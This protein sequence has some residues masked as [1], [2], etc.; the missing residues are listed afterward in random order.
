MGRNKYGYP[1]PDQTKFARSKKHKQEF[2]EGGK[3]AKEDSWYDVAKAAVTGKETENQRAAKVAKWAAPDTPEQTA[4][5]AA[6][7]DKQAAADKAALKLK[8]QPRN[9]DTSSVGSLQKHKRDVD[10]AAG[11][12]TGDVQTK[13][14]GGIV[15]AKARGVGIALR[16]HGKGKMR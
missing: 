1:V 15:K 7:A 14:R 6:E 11:T 8:P 16:G 5:K 4:A 9:E 10:E 3:V 13:K 12:T 2:V